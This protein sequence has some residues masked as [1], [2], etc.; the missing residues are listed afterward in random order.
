[1]L[2]ATNVTRGTILA[3]EI[4]VAGTLWARFMGLMGRRMLSAG[5]GLW[6]PGSNG[7][8]MFFMRLRIDAVFLGPAH[9]DGARRVRSVHRELRPWTGIVPF[10]WGADGVLELPPGTIDASATEAGDAI[11]LD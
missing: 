8:H 7:I 11:R 6:L 4:E 5:H 9:A 10:V 3:D 2:T 1:V